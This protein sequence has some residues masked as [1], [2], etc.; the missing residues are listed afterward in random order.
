M[1]PDSPNISR[2][3]WK[4]KIGDNHTYLYDIYIYKMLDHYEH[5]LNHISPINEY[6]ISIIV[7]LSSGSEILT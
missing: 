6:N 1:S 4:T 2:S 5:Q 3:K 7:L